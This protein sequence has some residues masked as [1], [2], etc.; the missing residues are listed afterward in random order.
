MPSLLSQKQKCLR[1]VIY[2]RT[3]T[4]KVDSSHTRYA[5]IFLK[6]DCERSRRLRRRAPNIQLQR[7]IRRQGSFFLIS[8]CYVQSSCRKTLVWD[9]FYTGNQFDF[10]AIHFEL[11]Q[12]RDHWSA[13]NFV[14]VYSA[15]S[16]L[17]KPVFYHATSCVCLF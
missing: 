16:V 4:I 13:G 2:C 12:P 17:G 15:V 1:W 11:Y 3:F 9:L 14:C 6:V 10:I 8:W 7:R 5:P